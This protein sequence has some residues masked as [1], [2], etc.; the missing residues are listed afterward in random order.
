M[1]SENKR[2]ELVVLETRGLKKS[3]LTS[4]FRICHQGSFCYWYF[5]SPDFFTDPQRLVLRR[6]QEDTQLSSNTP[7]AAVLEISEN[8]RS[9]IYSIFCKLGKNE[10]QCKV[11]PSCL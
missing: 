2:V 3:G 10:M 9:K 5:L 6:D 7:S 11:V 1:S 8:L 4:L